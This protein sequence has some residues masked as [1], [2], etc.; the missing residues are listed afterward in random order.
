MTLSK[1]A[2]II[3][4]TAKA[5]ALKSQAVSP[6]TRPLPPLLYFTDPE[7]SPDPLATVRG[8]PPGAGV[9]YRHFGRPDA[10]ALGQALRL[11]TAELG[12]VLLVG[13]DADLAREIEADGVHLPER[14]L[15]QAI[16]LR[17]H[18][19]H[20]LLTGAVHQAEAL[21]LAQPLDA[22]VISPVFPAGG[23]SA[24]KADLGLERFKALCAQAP[25]PVYG[26]GGITAARAPLMLETGACGIAGVD[27]LQAAF[28]SGS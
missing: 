18:Y 15:D 28:A 26:L 12:L 20:G 16:A 1:D 23:R 3:W 2:R 27:A 24:S 21:S 5:L 4:Q 13:L 19:P 8:L 17:R 9:V 25:C 10:R 6:Q 22:C 11:A 14:A 7:R